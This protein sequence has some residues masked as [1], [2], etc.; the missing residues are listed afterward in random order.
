MTY[1]IKNFR[2][3]E[4]VPEKPGVTKRVVIGPEDGAPNFT[5]RIIEVE[6]KAAVPMHTHVWEHEIFVLS[7]KGALLLE[8]GEKP[9]EKDSVVYMPPN[10]VH[11]FAN[12]GDETLRLICLIPNMD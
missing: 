1:K 6:P 8:D 7:G 9:A 4:P 2:D 10:L 11:G 12:K 5:M 3:V